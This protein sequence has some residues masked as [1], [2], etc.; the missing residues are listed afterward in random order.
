LNDLGYLIFDHRCF[1]SLG[2]RNWAVVF[3]GAMLNETANA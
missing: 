1:K 3:P 2:E